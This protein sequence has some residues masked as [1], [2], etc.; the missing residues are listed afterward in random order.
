MSED[1]LLESR[2]SMPLL[3]VIWPGKMVCQR[4]AQSSKPRIKCADASQV[5]V[6]KMFLA[7]ENTELMR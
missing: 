4:S 1:E 5:P 7:A 3:L 6:V 2:T